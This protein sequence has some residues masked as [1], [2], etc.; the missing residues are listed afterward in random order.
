MKGMHKKALAGIGSLA[1]LILMFVWL[2]GNLSCEGKVPPGRQEV[3]ESAAAALKTL[4]VSA[5]SVPVFMEAVGTVSARESVEISSKVMATILEASADSG[6]QVKRGDALFTLDSRDAR[7]RVSRAREELARAEAEL[8]RIELDAG[9][10]ERLY[11]RQAATKQEYDRAQSALKAA[12][13]LVEGAKAAVREAEVN[14]SYT[15]IKSPM[16]GKVIDRLADAGDMAAP[17]RTLLTL[18]AP[19]TLR[20]EVSVPEHL[21]QKVRTGDTVG[22]AIDSLGL[23]FEGQIVEIVPAADILSRSFTVRVSLPQNEAISPGM[24]GRMKLPTGSTEAVLIP[25]EAVRTVGQLQMVT[26]LKDGRARTQT[27]KL[28]KQYASGVEVLAG[29]RPGDV[30]AVP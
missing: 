2:T 29:L 3:G 21:R 6:Q 11:E 26:V 20:L 15:R 27:V 25:P 30:I 28:G 8:S 4:E 9:R 19:S 17:G 13:A 5:T 10:M 22:V 18:Y 7:A 24:Y 23:A 1:F 16:D 14:L 12:K